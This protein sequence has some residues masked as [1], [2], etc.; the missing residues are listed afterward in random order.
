MTDY[1]A[2]AKQLLL[3][4]RAQLRE[5]VKS[6]PDLA[7]DA[8][9]Y[10]FGGSF[11]VAGIFYLQL[12]SVTPMEFTNGAKLS[13]RGEGGGA[14]FG[15]GVF[16]GGGIF[17]VDPATL[18]GKEVAFLVAAGPGVPA[19]LAITWILNFVPIGNFLGGG[20]S[21]FAGAGG[22]SGKFERR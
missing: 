21:A 6:S 19:P 5:L 3:S 8:N 7:D 10:P 15:G 16:A 20:I 14:V 12:F 9:L 4:S 18:V 1:Q 17:T 13:Y 22:G 11:S 2:E